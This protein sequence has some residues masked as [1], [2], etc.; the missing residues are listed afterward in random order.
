LE[1]SCLYVYVDI[2]EELSRG[3]MR[4]RKGDKHYKA[5]W[6]MEI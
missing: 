6:F 4:G 2:L 3:V 1:V 5:S